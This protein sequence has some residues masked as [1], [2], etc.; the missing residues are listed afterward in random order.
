[1]REAED[2]HCYPAVTGHGNLKEEE[3]GNEADYEK[4]DQNED[5]DIQK[6]SATRY[7]LL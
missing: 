3:N 5:N 4:R 6:V 1:M 2:I 7:V